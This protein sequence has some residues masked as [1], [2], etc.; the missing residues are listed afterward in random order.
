[1]D[2]NHAILDLVTELYAIV[3]GPA[4]KKRDWAR[5]AELF[6]P[7]AHMIRTVVDGQG[8]PRAQVIKACD[9]GANFEAKIGDQPFYE[10]E[11]HR[12][13]E[14]FG[15]IAHV[16]STYEAYADEARTRFLKRGINSIQLYHDGDGWKIT[17]MVWDDERPG[18]E[19]PARY[20]G[21]AATSP[22]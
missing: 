2:P 18:L 22:G 3:S 7:Q 5:E 1:M 15:N 9:Y 21:G 8:Q 17:S 6:M 10:H 19:M 20:R 11:V 13:I 12:I 16:F 4:G 14:H